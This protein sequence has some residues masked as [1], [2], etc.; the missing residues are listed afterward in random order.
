MPSKKA[1]I[2]WVVVSY[3][4]IAGGVMLAAATLALLGVASE[5]ASQA[6][7][8]VGALI[9]GVVAGRASPHKAVAEPAIGG[10]L[11]VATLVGVFVTELPWA[12]SWGADG[13]IPVA[14]R[15]A[16][17]SGLGGLVGGLIGRRSRRGLLRHSALRWWGV[18]V[19]IHLGTTFM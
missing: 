12:A 17:I 10:L 6:V 14:L 13:A 1:L 3:F 9:G 18:S 8:F 11:V 19:L 4:L 15:M 5:L 2:G 16:L 7:L